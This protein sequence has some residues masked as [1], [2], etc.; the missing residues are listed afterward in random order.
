LYGFSVKAYDLA[1]I[2]GRGGTSGIGTGA[3]ESGGFILDGGH[4]FGEQGGKSEFRPTSA[5]SGIKPA[6]VTARHTFPD[7]WQI[8]IFLPSLNSLV[9]GHLE[10]E[11]FNES[12]PVPIGEVQEICHEVVMRMLPG[13]AENDINLFG[14]AVNRIQDLGFKKLEIARNSPIIPALI[15]GLRKA[16]SPCTGMSSFGP[17]VY[18][19]TETG[20]ADLEREGREI[21]GDTPCQVICTKGNNDG[22]IIRWTNSPPFLDPL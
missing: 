3:F 5:S 22:A 4:T 6:M 21:L 14:A 9:S 2:V 8:I 11:F 1:H 10:A 19:I 17:A 12:C 18:A 15:S 16:G 7:S 20:I 13:I